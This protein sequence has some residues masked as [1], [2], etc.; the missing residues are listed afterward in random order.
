MT[1]T[2]SAVIPA[3]NCEQYIARAIDSVLNQ[4]FPANEIIVIDDGSSDGTV[5]R[6]RSYGDKV[7]LIQQ[8]NAGASAA[9]NAGIQAATGDW[10]AFLDADDE[11]L[12]DTLEIQ[13]NILMQKPEL[14]WTTGNYKRCFCKKDY[15]LVQEDPKRVGFFLKGKGFFD[16]Y[17]DIFTHKI[18]GW[19]GC[20]MIR[21]DVLEE[22]GLFSTDLPRANDIDMWFRVAYRHPQI[23][24]SVEPLAIYHMETGDSLASHHMTYDYIE[25]YLQKHLK[26]ADEAGRIE[27]FSPCAS[28]MLRA[29]IRS[30]LFDDRVYDIRK[31]MQSLDS[32]LSARYRG[33]MW[34]MTVWPGLTK[35][36]FLSLSWISRTL[37]LRRQTWHTKEQYNR[38][39]GG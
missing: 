27:A 24:F 2:I 33:I 25:R 15:A 12:P 1:L 8:Q 10:V 7:K 18:R 20:M 11:W 22:V 34:L 4:T 13:S 17:L 30:G 38:K 36:L 26:L 31:V 16:D 23:G 6:V 29:W 35:R 39:D 28:Q 32:L 9:R 19:T 14:V 5:E 37:K 21:R 3:Y